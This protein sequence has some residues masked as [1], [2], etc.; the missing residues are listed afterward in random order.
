[1]VVSDVEPLEDFRMMEAPSLA[2]F[3][4][5]ADED[6]PVT[7]PVEISFTSLPFGRVVSR[8][9][10]EDREVLVDAHSRSSEETSWIEEA[11]AEASDSI[12]DKLNFRYLI[13]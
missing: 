8:V 1:M 3:E 2:D 5:M 13:R 6:I 7:G 10:D 12:S 11:E 4:A 9:G